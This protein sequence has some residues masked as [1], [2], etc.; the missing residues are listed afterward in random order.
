M[1]D[2]NLLDELMKLLN[3]PGPVNWALAGQV[4]GHLA[5][6]A[7]LIDPWLADEYRELT[8]LA[9]HQI[10]RTTGLPSDP[11]I[12]AVLVDRAGWTEHH[13]RSFHYLVDPLA[14][15]L[16]AG[17]GTGPL[18]AILR[19]LGPALVGMQ[20]GAMVGMMSEGVLGM[21]D[22][23]LPGSRTGLTLLVPNIETFSAEHGLDPRQVRLW[24]ALHEVAHGALVGRSW[25]RPHV[26]ELFDDLIGSMDLEMMADWQ[27]DLTDPAKLEAR[28]AQGGGF[29]GLFGGSVEDDRREA[30]RTLM[31]M[32]EGYGSYLV[33]RAAAGLLPDIRSVRAAMSSRQKG[34]LTGL[35][36]LFEIETAAGEYGRGGAFCAEVGERWGYPAV[37]RVWEREE[38]LPSSR[39]MDDVTGWAA[40]V[41]L[42]DPFAQ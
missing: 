36:S 31:T 27:E 19:Q 15:K 24:A 22:A 28:L 20:M 33:D 4:A 25:V 5:G 14:A 42:E 41:L 10:P 32:L 12:E 23:G 34:H 21:F 30:I 38:N 26:Q 18:D 40:R 2:R 7:Q 35:G 9:Q 1:P 3:Q 16:T 29:G 8:R 39:E 13:L 17:P 37:Q 11:M 6:S